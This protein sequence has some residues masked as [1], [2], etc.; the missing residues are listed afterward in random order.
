MSRPLILVSNVLVWLLGVAI[1]YGKGYD[2]EFNRVLLSFVT[3]LIVSASVHFTNEYADFETDALTTRTPYSGGSGVLL[4]GLV[5]RSL[6]LKAALT[7]LLIGLVVQLFALAYG[8]H[9]WIAL[10]VLV[11]GALGGYMYSLPPLKLG[12]RG[13]GE[14]VN[15]FLGSTLLPLYGFI[16]T[17]GT[18]HYSVVISCLPVT[19]TAFTNL[20][21]VTW[22]DR[23]SDVSVGKM[24]LATR[25][26]PK[27]LR[28][29]YRG[30]VVTIFAS[31]IFLRGWVLPEKIVL[32]SLMAL[33][34]LIWGAFTF[35]RNE[36]S[37]ATVYGLIVMIIA[38]TV[39]WFFIGL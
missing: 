1:A 38:Q 13:C 17:S 4:K 15:A 20:L 6:A 39:T 26:T 34:F 10:I 14:V 37:R 33:P 24:T 9:S 12:W 23:V 5:P 31:L 8:I 32:S 25:L 2:L 29:L 36:I 28:N 22:P 19:L 27:S 3:S 11:L 21:A 30:S 18:F 7:S 16:T 35:T